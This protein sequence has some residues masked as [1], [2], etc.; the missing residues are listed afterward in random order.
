MA[1]GNFIQ[2]LLQIGRLDIEE[3]GAAYSAEWHS[4]RARMPHESR[5]RI[6]EGKFI[7]RQP[8]W[9]MIRKSRCGIILRI[10]SIGGDTVQEVDHL[11]CSG[12]RSFGVCPKQC[13]IAR[14]I[15]RLDS[16]SVLQPRHVLLEFILD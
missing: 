13:E 9:T 12:E 8:F 2:H 3:N 10:Q 7:R 1:A 4:A 14:T 16:G 5:D 15:K 11:L 6:R